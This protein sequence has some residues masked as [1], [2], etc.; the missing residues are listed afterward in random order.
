MM[1]G[2]M[3][4]IHAIPFHTTCFD[5]KRSLS[6]VLYKALKIKIKCYYLRHPSN[7]TKIFIKIK[8]KFF[9]VSHV[10]SRL[11]NHCDLF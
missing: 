3:N 9:I 5:R 10:S 11:C 1:H 7:T 2:T 4:V 6:R 8:L